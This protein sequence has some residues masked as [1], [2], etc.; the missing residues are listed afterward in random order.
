MPGP[1]FRIC[2][3]ASRPFSSGWLQIHDDNIGPKLPALLDRVASVGR[4]AHTSQPS[5]LFEERPNASP[6]DRVIVD[7]QDPQRHQS[8]SLTSGNRARTVVP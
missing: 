8:A 5:W 6:H 2:R 7:D 3:V 1:S 4:F